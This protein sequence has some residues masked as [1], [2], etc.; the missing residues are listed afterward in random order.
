ERLATFQVR[1]SDI[2]M[3]DHVNNTKYSQ[4]ILDAMPIEWH[5]K[6][7]LERYQIC[8]LN[9]AKLGDSVDVSIAVLEGDENSAR[10][11]VQYQGFRVADSKPIFTAILESRLRL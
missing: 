9:E 10:S 8:F 7:K 2:D 6:Y 1:N 3:N 11:K 4:W 5:R